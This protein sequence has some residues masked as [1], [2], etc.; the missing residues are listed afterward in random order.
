MRKTSMSSGI[1]Q[2]KPEEIDRPEKRGKYRVG[3]VGCGQN[4]I[5]HAYLFAEAGFKVICADSDQTIVSLLSKGKTSFLSREMES[6]LRNHIK[7]KRLHATD[8][9]KATVSNSDIIIIAISP[10]I[11]AKRRIDQSELEKACKQ[12]GSCIS[13]GSL[14]IIAGVVGLGTTEGLI[15]EIL[16]N[17]SGLKAGNGF[18]LAYSPT[19]T[20][21]GQTIDSIMNHQRLVAAVDRNSLDTAST[22]LATITRNVEK[23][24][25]VRA[26][27]LAVLFEATKQDVDAALAN[28]FA[29]F[30]EKAHVDLLE[31]HRLATAGQEPYL[32]TPMMTGRDNPWEIYLLLEDAENLNVKL[33]MPT[34]AREINGG[35]VKHSVNLTKDALRSCGKS[36]RRA[37]ISVLGISRVQNVKDSPRKIVKGIV[38]SLE[39]KGSR[40]SLYDPYFS[41]DEL[42]EMS[43]QFK[44]NISESVENADCIL[45]LTGHE[46]FR[47]LNL[48][49]LKVVM[50]MPAAIVDLEGVIEPDKVEKEGFIYRGLGRG[51]WTK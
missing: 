49:K 39:A 36:L 29:L 34:V 51:V 15:K 12:I 14:V 23:T 33:R 40:V 10:K 48:K 35:I 42:R 3:I 6:R 50:K 47:R 4:G 46:Q 30:C 5:L 8:D 2:T 24:Q 19:Q 18:G 32:P 31:S 27:E 20:L 7:M 37:R 41:G 45:I 22:V 44:K 21:S 13:R 11:D 9:T 28:E 17:T 38:K 16:E 25:N 1:I 26:A 43:S